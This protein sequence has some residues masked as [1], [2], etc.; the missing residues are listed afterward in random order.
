MKEKSQLKSNK[1][2]SNATSVKDHL[3]AEVDWH[4]TSVEHSNNCVVTSLKPVPFTN[5]TWPNHGSGIEGR[6]VCVCKC[7]FVWVC[8]CVCVC[9]CVCV[10]VCVCMCVYMIVHVCVWA[11]VCVYMCAYVCMHVCIICVCMYIL[12]YAHKLSTTACTH[13]STTANW[14]EESI[15][16]HSPLCPL[17]CS[18]HKMFTVGRVASPIRTCTVNHYPHA[19]T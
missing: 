15:W 6:N 9:Q 18:E 17:F 16:E 1:A 14:D 13:M 3:K 11:Y 12:V 19:I 10:F 7:V 8:V 4:C 2:L 5:Y